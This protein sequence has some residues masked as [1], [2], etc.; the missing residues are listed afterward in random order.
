M[1][2]EF[3]AFLRMRRK[4]PRS[5]NRELSGIGW[6]DAQIRNRSCGIS[7][8]SQVERLAL[9]AF[10]LGLP[11]FSNEV[12]EQIANGTLQPGQNLISDE[13]NSDDGRQA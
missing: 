9:T 12:A 13:P 3:E 2:P 7:K 6:N 10:A 1:I 8:L 4:G 11:A 5:L